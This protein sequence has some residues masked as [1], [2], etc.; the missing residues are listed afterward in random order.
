MNDRPT[1]VCLCGSTRFRDAFFDASRVESL[2]GRIVVRPELSSQADAVE[3]DDDTARRLGCFTEARSISLMRYSS[4]TSM[5]MS[6]RP[7][8]PKL[9]M[10]CSSG[11]ASGTGPSPSR[12]DLVLPPDG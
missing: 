4:L 8:E 5:A 9:R 7:P 2:A 1:I 12:V 10:R 6:V 11:S 3:L